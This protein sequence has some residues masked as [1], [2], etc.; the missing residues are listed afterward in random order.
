MEKRP[1]N[2]TQASLYIISTMYEISGGGGAQLLLSSAAGG[3]GPCPTLSTPM[4]AVL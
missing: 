1:K 2:S 4:D 3:H